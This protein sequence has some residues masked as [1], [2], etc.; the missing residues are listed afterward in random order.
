MLNQFLQLYATDT[1]KWDDVASLSET[2]GWMNFTEQTTASY[3]SSHG[4]SDQY[5]YE[6]IE[7]GTRV[8]YGQVSET[9]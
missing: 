4:V 7:A 1:P 9:L 3:F 5:I 8:N 6:V 2:F